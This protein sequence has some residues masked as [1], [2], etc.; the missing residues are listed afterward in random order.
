ME[1]EVLKSLLVSGFGIQKYIIPA[2]LYYRQNI[3]FF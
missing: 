1:W 3:D 2:A